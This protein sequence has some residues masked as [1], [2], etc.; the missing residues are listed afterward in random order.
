MTSDSVRQSARRPITPDGHSRTN[1]RRVGGAGGW[2]TTLADVAAG[3]DVLAD[4]DDVPTDD[5][6]TVGHSAGG[7]LAVWLAARHRLAASAPGADPVVRPVAAVSQAGVVA[8][9]DAIEARLGDGAVEDLLGGRE[10]DR[11]AVADPAGLVPLGVPVVCVHGTEDDTVPVAQS[12]ALL[13]RMRAVGDDCVVRELP[14]GHMD[15]IDPAHPL[16]L[17]VLDELRRL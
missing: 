5:V 7:H 4:L 11:L 16:W 13:R 12:R 8:L 1:S 9:D 17:A 14:G 15:V 10:P 3:L 6:V 2:P